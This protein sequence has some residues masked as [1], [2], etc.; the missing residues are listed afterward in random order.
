MAQLCV[1]R[2]SSALR[3]SN[4]GSRTGVV[5][6]LTCIKGRLGIMHLV[7]S[8]H[9]DLTQRTPPTYRL[10]RTTTDRSIDCLSRAASK[11]TYRK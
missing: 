3:P 1:V 6:A 11:E 2:Q 4:G 7:H 8:M 9:T 10:S 5:G